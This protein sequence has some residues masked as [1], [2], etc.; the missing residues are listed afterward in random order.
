MKRLNVLI[1][2]FAG[3]LLM[4]GCARPGRILMHPAGE[5]DRQFSATISRTVGYR[6]HLYIPPADTVNQLYP[7]L[8]FLHGIGERGE[9]LELVKKH[10]LNNMLLAHDPLSFVVISPQ[11]PDE[12]WWNSEI[13]NA[14]I[15]H[16]L[17]AY[18][19]NPERVY[20]TGLS[21][22]GS[23][24]WEVITRY[25]DRF[26]AAIPICGWGNRLMVHRAM[27]IPVWVFHGEDDP[28]IPLKRSEEMVNAL[29]EAGG[30]VNF[31]VYPG[32]GHDAWTKTY[33][34]PEIYDWLLKNKL[35]QEK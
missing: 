2:L 31:T 13:L 9:D 35:K 18:P 4:T 1:W 22:G 14:L 21:M 30:T 33:R 11:L 7:L 8:L 25:P 28:V 29:K 10:G 19:I 34:N 32:T 20:I 17:D 6:Y 5:Y 15:D 24:V 3:L 16:A 27:N 12:E 26:A 23:G